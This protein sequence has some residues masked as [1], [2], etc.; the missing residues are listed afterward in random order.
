MATKRGFQW[1]TGDVSWLEYGAKWVREIPGS[2][3]QRYHVLSFDNWSEYEREP[4]LKYMVDLS[5]IDLASIPEETKASALES[6]G[7]EPPGVDEIPEAQR[8]LMLVEALH[9]YGAKAP[10]FD[11]SGNNAGKLIR[12]AK[13]CSYEVTASCEAY[14]QAMAKPVNKLG[15]TAREFMTGDIDSAIGRGLEA[16]DHNAEIVALMMRG[17]RS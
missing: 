17:K 7:W 4:E 3:G 16:G 15:S 8:R 6:C 10:L 9:G 11:V 2:N 13:A 14:E 1:L 12:A 5:E